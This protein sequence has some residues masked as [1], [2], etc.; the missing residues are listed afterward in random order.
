MFARY[1]L[2]VCQLTG[3][4]ASQ[5]SKYISASKATVEAITIDMIC[6]FRKLVKN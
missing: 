5:N 2:L 1:A 4:Y 6:N 3:K